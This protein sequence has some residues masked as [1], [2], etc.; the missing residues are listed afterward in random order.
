MAAATGGSNAGQ[1]AAASRSGDASAGNR[2]SGSSASGGS[3]SSGSGSS[4]GNAGAGNSKSGRLGADAYA[5]PKYALGHPRTDAYKN[6]MAR[7]Y[8]FV[9]DQATADRVKR[10]ASPDPTTQELVKQL[11]RYP[12][13]NTDTSAVKGTGYI[14]F[15]LQS[16][17]HQFQEKVEVVET[18]AD[19]YAAYAYGSQ[20]PTYRYS[21]ALLN[22]KQ[23]DHAANMFRIY[24]SFLRALQLAEAKLEVIFQYNQMVV[25]GAMTSLSWTLTGADESVCMGN[26]DILVRKT[27][28]L[29][30]QQRDSS[31]VPDGDAAP[32]TAEVYKTITTGTIQPDKTVGLVFA[33]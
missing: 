25:T 9:A 30:T 14:Q 7:L 15:L 6:T 20:P 22:S 31:F 16:A 18:L 8:V 32:N 2:S 26:F 11:L 4:G 1:A 21:V 3:S 27:L 23:D 17:T 13:N 29:D 10:H 12:E 19:K 5:T 24:W 28:L 33:T